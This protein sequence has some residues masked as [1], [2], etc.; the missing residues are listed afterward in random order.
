MLSRQLHVSND[1][2][3]NEAVFDSH[4]QAADSMHYLGNIP[5]ALVDIPYVDVGLHPGPWSSPTGY[6]GTCKLLE[7]DTPP[8][9]YIGTNWS[10]DFRTPVIDKS[11]LSST[12]T[13]WSVRVLK[14]EKMSFKGLHQLI[15]N[16]TSTLITMMQSWRWRIG[17]C[18]NIQWRCPSGIQTQRP[19]KSSRQTR[20]Y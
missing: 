1:R 19:S 15:R 13:V 8:E 4:L 17:E 3:T 10:T 16:W 2:A 12:V 5:R 14:T 20:V 11:F 9:K 18:W 7:S 6:S